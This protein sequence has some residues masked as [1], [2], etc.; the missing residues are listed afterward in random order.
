MKL[1]T[2]IL[3]KNGIS[4]GQEINDDE[5]HELVKSSE[6]RRAE[7]KA[8]YLL[9]YRA[10]SR[11]ELIDRISEE[12]SPEAA[13]AAAEHLESLGLIDDRAFA[14][15]FARQLY[16]VKKYGTMRVRQEMYRKGID[17]AIVDEIVDRY[18]HGAE[19][20]IVQII[21]KKYP[22]YASDEKVRRRAVAALQRMGYR[23]DEI[24]TALGNMNSEEDYYD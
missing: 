23:Y 3:Q 2:F 8:L 10:R 14:E 6:K 13:E 18:S 20:K 24:R 21:E 15:S 17:R 22:L 9:E 16:E 5:L 7:E 4:E 19:D 11:K 1:D 12:S